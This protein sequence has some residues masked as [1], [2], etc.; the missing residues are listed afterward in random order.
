MQVMSAMV[1]GTVAF[2]M[3]WQA[4]SIS[5]SIAGLV[6]VYAMNFT[7]SATYLARNH[8]E[9]QMT[10]NC[11][12]RVMEYLSIEKEQY[13]SPVPPT[14]DTADTLVPLTRTASIARTA[15]TFEGESTAWPSLGEIV[16]DRICLRYRQ[17]S[18]LV[19]K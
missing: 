13:E 7:D 19:L 17:S 12:E 14:A 10:M 5:S 1:S 2:A 3:L 6:I 16:F 15:R 18:P 9:C 8:S 4:Q 11:V